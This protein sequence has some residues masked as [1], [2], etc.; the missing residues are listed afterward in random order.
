MHWTLELTSHFRVQYLFALFVA[1]VAFASARRFRWALLWAGLAV[2]NA[3]TLA[4]LYVDPV[5]TN[6]G[7]RLRALHINIS[8]RNKSYESVLALVNEIKPHVLFIA[9]ITPAW[10]R[11]LEPLAE[12][13]PYSLAEPTDDNFGI[14]LFS[15]LPLE[16][17]HVIRLGTRPVPSIRATPSSRPAR[18]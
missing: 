11:A 4:P 1:A 8:Y 5:E 10:T 2:V 3:L 12:S 6:D 16:D 14:A 18:P 13:Y 9:E 7:L 15:K 17:A